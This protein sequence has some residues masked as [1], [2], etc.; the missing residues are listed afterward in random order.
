M[1]DRDPDRI[2]PALLI[3][4]TLVTGLV[5][6]VSYLS[7]GHVF[8]GNMTGNVVLLG[9]ALASSPGLSVGRAGAALAAFAA[10]ALLATRMVARVE[11]RPRLRWASLGFGVE[12]VLLLA[13]AVSAAG[14][15]GD[16]LDDP[17]RLYVLIVLTGLAMGVRNAV[18]RKLA[19]RDLTTTTVLTTTIVGMAADS[20]LAGGRSKGWARRAFSIVSMFG[21]AAAGAWL[22]RYSTAFAIACAG[23]TS[24]ACAVIA[25]T[26]APD[27]PH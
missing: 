15:R 2:L 25:R 20:S 8:T 21:G 3:A 10:G 6:A 24:A 13:G 26:R 18:V 23:F 27:S 7:L 12:A 19:E 22:V 16:L 11:T 1:N 17:V 14:A 9:F 5:D 4:L